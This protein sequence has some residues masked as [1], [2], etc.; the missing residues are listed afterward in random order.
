MQQ[1]ADEDGASN[2]YAQIPQEWLT[3]PQRYFLR[4]P[5]GMVAVFA[6]PAFKPR[7]ARVMPWPCIAVIDRNGYRVQYVHDDHNTLVAVLDSVGRVYR[8]A[9]TQVTPIRRSDSGQR[10][11]GVVLAF[12]PMTDGQRRSMLTE[13]EL[14]RLLR[15][16]LPEE[17]TNS[18][19]STHVTATKVGH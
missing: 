5:E 12:D 13:Q 18:T 6:P 2:P 3:D 17:G 8:L 1:I 14:A 19:H 10:L 7:G 4:S 11:A 15:S 9:L 16:P